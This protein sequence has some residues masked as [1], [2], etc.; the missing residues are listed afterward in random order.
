MC[1]G[2][3]ERGGYMCAYKG[4]RQ[5]ITVLLV[6]LVPTHED[7]NALLQPSRN[8]VGNMSACCL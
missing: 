6:L 7:S 1:E 3:R 5:L 4:I 8:Y 2:I